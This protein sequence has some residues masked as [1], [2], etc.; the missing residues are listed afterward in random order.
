MRPEVRMAP[1][2]DRRVYSLMSEQRIPMDARP[3]V[4][5]Y[6]G[7]LLPLSETFIK[8]QLLA[9][10]RWRGVLTGQRQLNELPLEGLPI[11]VLRPTD[12][13]IL[14]RARWK[15]SEAAGTLPGAVVEQLKRSK[16]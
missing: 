15:V 1:Y 5:V 8:Q 16:P 13:S 9:L 12:R 4:L 2:G 10:S 7:D 6:R 14:E 11:E 3:T